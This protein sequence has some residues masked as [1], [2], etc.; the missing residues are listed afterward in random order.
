MRAQPF[1]TLCKLLIGL[2]LV[3]MTLNSPAAQQ[4][5]PTD[6]GKIKK[7]QDAAGNWHYG[8]TADEACRQSKIIEMNKRG[9]ETK[10]VAAPLTDEQRKTQEIEEV[11]KEKAAQLAA[12]RARRDKILVSIYANE[13][14]I[15]A[16]RDRKLAEI[17]AQIR[18][19]QATLAAQQGAL[20]R[21]QA[22]AKAESNGKPVPE[23]TQTGIGK[24]EAVIAKQ[25]AFI[26]S[27][28]QE[29]AAVKQQ[30][31]ADLERYR[32]LK[33]KPAEKQ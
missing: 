1:I 20:A 33:T 27:K 9:I 11:E 12:E 5:S 16:M 13:G 18:G 4:S 29:Q 17:D 6:K 8:D 26:Q 31:Q 19:S 28:L 15:T 3:G 22:K 2:G 24:A 10:E 7:C 21:L 23:Q 30:F 25:A 14:D 32:Q